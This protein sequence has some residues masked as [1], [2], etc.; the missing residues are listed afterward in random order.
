MIDMKLLAMFY[1]IYKIMQNNIGLILTQED[2]IKKNLIDGK[3]MKI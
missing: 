2:Q 1:L 3:Y